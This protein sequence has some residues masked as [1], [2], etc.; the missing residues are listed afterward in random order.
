LVDDFR[1][2]YHSYINVEVVKGTVDGYKL[3]RH[4]GF[5]ARD[6]MVE[7]SGFLQWLSVYTLATNPG[8]DVLL[9]DE[10]DAHLH[11]SLQRELLEHLEALAVKAGKQVL[12][13]THSSEIL[14]AAEPDEILQMRS[15]GTAKYLQTQDQQVALLEG[16]GS[17][18]SPRIEAVRRSK[19][20]LFLEGSSDLAVLIALSETLGLPWPKE[21]VTW[22]TTASHKDRRHLWRALTEDF[23][24]LTA[25]SLRDRDDQALGTVDHELRDTGEAAG[26]EVAGFYARKWRRRYIEA[27][28]LWPPTLAECSGKS[29]DEVRTLLQDDF[30][31]AIG[32]TFPVSQ[33]PQ[34][35]LDVRAKEILSALGIGAVEVA[36]KLPAEAICEDVRMVLA[37]L[38]ELAV[39]TTESS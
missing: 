2:E 25:Y 36:K 3:T 31:I 23:G 18:Y 38:Q 35:L 10:P 7:G 30:G 1:E 6:L 20:I 29:E 15:A 19:R 4:P 13:A 26:F 27:Y 8:L 21:W 5:N 14:R 32:A 16:L 28:L 17:D 11:P 34:A 12:L 33:A 39:P 22:P 24:S 37:Q 9:F